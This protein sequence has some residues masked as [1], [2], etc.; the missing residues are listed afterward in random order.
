MSNPLKMFK[1]GSLDSPS[2]AQN[3]KG[4]MT[5]ARAEKEEKTIRS[6]NVDRLMTATVADR[7]RFS[8]L[9]KSEAV[10]SSASCTDILSVSGIAAT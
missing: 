7:R 6:S 3:Q 8:E 1:A 9:S 5:E 4:K 2:R 10:A